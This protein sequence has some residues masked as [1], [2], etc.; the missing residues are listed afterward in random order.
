MLSK[1][2][3]NHLNHFLLIMAVLWGMQA[4]AQVFTVSVAPTAV[5]KSCFSG[6]Y[7][8]T[9]TVTVSPPRGYVYGTDFTLNTSLCTFKLRNTSNSVLL[10][11]TGGTQSQNTISGSFNM[12]AYTA[13]AYNILATISVNNIRDNMTQIVSGTGYFSVGYQANWQ[14]MKDMTADP[15]TWS[16]KRNQTSSGVTYARALSSNK[17]AAGTNGWMEIGAQFYTL[18]LSS[19]YF[20]LGNNTAGI[21]DPTAQSDYI[22]F[23][24]TGTVS[25]TIYVKTGGT[26]TALTGVD[27]SS[28]LLIRRTSGQITFYNAANQTII[29]GAPTISYTGE[30]NVGV[31]ATTLNDG[32]SN[33]VTSFP[34][35]FEQFFYLKDEVEQSVAYVSGSK[36]KFKFEEDYF[37]AAGTLNY[38][39]TCLNND[40]N[41]SLLTITKPAH[42]NWIEIALGSGGISLTSGYIYLLEVR[43]AKGRKKY[44]KFKKA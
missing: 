9:Y 20:V 36:L 13:E 43:D 30:L 6:S 17:L 3:L 44:L 39:I 37:D 40:V 14:S 5:H 28:R 11:N 26:L 35:V 4:N 34:C 31:F 22:E 33:I 41:P 29:S 25:G 8:V 10:T 18:N 23:R 24:K 7:S 2:H 16:A 27:Y 1:N 32:A 21:T 19:V 42:T 12:S 15:N 38:S